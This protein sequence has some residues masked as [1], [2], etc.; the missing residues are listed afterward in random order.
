MRNVY[1]TKPSLTHEYNGQYVKY[2]E[3]WEAMTN[4]VPAKVP[5]RS[6]VIPMAQ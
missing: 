5:F 1:T 6:P 4:N 3:N 2:T